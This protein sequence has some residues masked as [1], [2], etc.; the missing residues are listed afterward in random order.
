MI[1]CLKTS[2]EAQASGSIRVIEGTIEPAAATAHAQAQEPADAGG[3][4]GS[5]PKG[6]H[7][8]QDATASGRVISTVW[9]LVFFE[10]EDLPC[11]AME[12]L[13]RHRQSLQKS[14]NRSGAI[15][16]YRTVCWMFLCP[17]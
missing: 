4:H 8:A 3:R 14:L 13:P 1:E 5:R 10:R 15:S 16:V 7:S 12:I 9:R 2:L 11:G 17:R 6:A